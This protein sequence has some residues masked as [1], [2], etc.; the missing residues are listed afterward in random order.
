MIWR[1]FPFSGVWAIGVLVGVLMLMSGMTFITIGGAVVAGI[2]LG[3]VVGIVVSRKYRLSWDEQS[4]QVVAQ[5]DWVGGII[6]A[7]YV[8]F[9]LGREWIFGHWIPAVSLTVF[10]LCVSAGSMIGQLVGAE[11]GVAFAMQAIGMGNTE[12]V[13]HDP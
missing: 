2:L 5:V 4:M 11:R 12:E 3:L 7:V 6:L 13:D 9:I 1:Q 10:C 8:L